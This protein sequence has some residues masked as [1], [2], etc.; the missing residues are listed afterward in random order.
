MNNQPLQR[1]TQAR[2]GLGLPGPRSSIPS[3]T[4]PRGKMSTSGQRLRRVRES[5]KVQGGQQAQLVEDC[6]TH[7]LGLVDQQHRAQQ[8][9]HRQ[10]GTG[11]CEHARGAHGVGISRG[12]LLNGYGSVTDLSDALHAVLGAFML[13]FLRKGRLIR[14]MDSAFNAL[15]S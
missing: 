14:L 2:R 5:L 10:A 6:R 9:R 7:F 4:P 12:R 13:V 3:R 1:S 15:S 11:H 8:G